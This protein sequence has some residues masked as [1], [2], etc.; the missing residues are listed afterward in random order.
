MGVKGRRTRPGDI[1]IEAKWSRR[2][3]GEKERGHVWL[4]EVNRTNVFSG[5]MRGKHST[6]EV[7]RR[8]N[9]TCK[10]KSSLGAPG[11]T[12]KVWTWI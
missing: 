9:Q 11:M 7:E 6:R 4:I 10:Q 2:W 5:V 12:S 8:R 1:E 3:E